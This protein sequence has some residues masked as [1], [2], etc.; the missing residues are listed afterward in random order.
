[1]NQVTSFGDWLRQGRKAL[2][3]TQEDLA[4]RIGCAA[5]TIRKIEAG[6]RRPSRQVA[7]LLAETLGITPEDRSHFVQLARMYTLAGSITPQPALSKRPVSNLPAPVTSFIGRN[8]EINTLRALL[9][10]E[11]VRLLTLTGAGGS[12]KTRLALQL[13]AR[14]LR[15]YPAGVFFVDLASR[16]DS[17]SV[18]QVVASVLAVKEQP[19]Q[20]VVHS[21]VEY[22]QQRELLLILDNC[23]HILEACASLAHQLLADCPRLGILATSRQPLNV[24]GELPWRVPPMSLPGVHKPIAPNDL[25][26]YE[27]VQLFVARAQPRRSSFAITPTNAEA[28]A[29][30]CHRLD[31]I[32][33]AIE[34]AAAR[35]GVLSVEEIE[36][37]LDERFRLLKSNEHDTIPRQQTLAAAM[38]WSYN[39][40][41]AAEQSLLRSLAVFAGGFTLDAACGIWA[42]EID[43]YEMIDLLAQLVD[44]SLV[45]VE[46][47][48]AKTR[49]SLLETTR[50]Y[51]WDKLRAA[52]ELEE[53]RDRHLHWCL[54]VAEEV[55]DTGPS[56]HQKLVRFNEE[57]DNLRAALEWSLSGGSNDPG[58]ALRI[59]VAMEGFWMHRSGQLAEGRGWLE[60]ALHGETAA[61]ALRGKAYRIAGTIAWIQGEY[62]RASE[63]HEQ[64]LLCYSES[65]DRGGMAW[66]MNNLAAQAHYQADYEPAMAWYTKALAMLRDLEDKEHIAGTLTNVGNLELELEQPERARGRYEEALE[67]FRE[68]GARGG[69][70]MVL[71]NVGELEHVRGDYA[72]ARRNY[73]QSMG[74]WREAGEPAGHSLTRHKLALVAQHEGKY[75]QAAMMHAVCLAEFRAGGQKTEMAMCLAALAGAAA[76]QEKP[77]LAARLLGA[78]DA[79]LEAIRSRL[80]PADAVEYRLNLAALRAR[81]G[82][83]AFD[84]AYE[85]GRAMPLD[86]AFETASQ[87]GSPPADQTLAPAATDARKPYP[88]GLTR[89]EVDVL[90]LVAAGLTNAQIAERLVISLSTVEAHLYRIFNKLGVSTRGAAVRFAVEHGL[91]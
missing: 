14:L 32:P 82:H 4:E 86:E 83:E 13:A 21:L 56:T 9:R 59:A 29:R 2:D 52:K 61:P 17:S 24:E 58:A 66:S 16:S 1:M 75:Q 67:L 39:L 6:R 27:A 38:D 70:A 89:R 80:E 15:R 25:R 53:L 47:R 41:S 49:Y 18:P 62:G 57:Q 81:L 11:D 72:E 30:L 46:E 79:L 88:N 45:Q 73:E 77:E 84:A 87:L 35:I 34:L 44:K 51:A 48:S 12:G 54:I 68:L 8:K 55:E 28:V 5:E 64:A 50:Q 90:R 20:P 26:K 69:M 40:L 91:T 22:L 78:A 37:R 74:M 19:G 42:G 43:E 3:L 85:Q 65:G 76:G 10:R 63:L 31:G 23:E 71:H 7:E 60:K 33:L 36:E